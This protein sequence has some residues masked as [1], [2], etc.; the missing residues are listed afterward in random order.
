MS[1]ENMAEEKIVSRTKRMDVIKCNDCG[2]IITFTSAIFV[3][4]ECVM[5]CKECA[6]TNN[7]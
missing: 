4:E 6:K 7:E 5:I 1:G 3:R 2:K